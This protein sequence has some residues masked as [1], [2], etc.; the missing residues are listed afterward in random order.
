MPSYGRPDRKFQGGTSATGTSFPAIWLAV[1]GV[2]L[3]VAE[4]LYQG[5]LAG[6]PGGSWGWLAG[7]SAIAA[8]AAG[9]AW[10]HGGRSARSVAVGLVVL[11]VLLGVAAVRLRSVAVSPAA[12]AVRAT[13]DAVQSRDRT[14]AASVAAAR[15]VGMLALQRV[16][17]AAPGQAPVLDDLLGG[18]SIEMGV[19]VLGGDTVVAVA[20]PQRVGAEPAGTAASLVETPFARL[21]LVTAVRGN[22]RAQVTLLLD[23][24]SALPS[25]G[26]ALATS[27]GRSRGVEWQWRDAGSTPPV[28][29][30]ESAMAT[31]SN[32]MQPVPPSATAMMSRELILARRL[33]IA[34][35]ILLSAIILGGGAPPLVRAAA[36]LLPLWVLVRG[37]LVLEGAGGAI[38]IA[39]LAG[40]ALLLL[41]VV[42]WQR[43]AHRAPVGVIAAVI[44]LAVAPWLVL[45]AASELAPPSEQGG[46]LTWF[47]WQAILAITTGAYLALASA[48][49]RARGDQSTHGRWG[50]LATLASLM[51]AVAG[52]ELWTPATSSGW[53]WWYP[54][55][56][57]IPFAAMLPVTSPRARRVSIFTAAASLAALGAW[58]S[59][60]GERLASARTDVE[61]L[62]SS[63]DPVTVN[64]LDQLGIALAQSKD[65]RLEQIY[66]TWHASPMAAERIPTQLA[67]WVDTT[68]IDWVALD[69]MAPSWGDLQRVVVAG[70]GSMSQVPLARGEGR[71]TALIVPLDGDTAVT[72]LA[73]PRSRIVRPT[74]FGRMIDW[75]VAADPPYT[76]HE[77][78]PD[79]ARPD[80]TF[81]RTGR[82]IR[83]DEWVRTGGRPLIVRATVS[84]DEPRPF[85]VRAALTVLLDVLL[86]M[87]VW[88]LVERF[89]G[90]RRGG[91]ADVFRRSYRRTVT[92]ALISFFVVPAAFFTL[93]SVLRLRQEVAHDRGQDVTRVLH[94]IDDEPVLDDPGLGALP[95]VALAQVADRVDAEVAVY[96]S[97]RLVAASAPL[98]A[99]LGLLSPVIDP[100]IVRAGPA[101]ER[102]LAAPVPGANVRVGGQVSTVPGLVLAAALPGGEGDLER[103]QVDLALLLLLASL[104]GTIAAVSVAGAVARA[105]GQPMESLRQRALAIGRRELAPPLRDPPAEF[106]PVFTAIAQMERDLGQSEA[107]LEEE[108]ARTAR[109][110]AWGEMARQVAHEIKNPLTPM[111]LG[112]Q[113][114]QRLGADGH[115]DLSD[116]VSATADRL[117]E[118][119]DRLDRIAR[120]FARYGAP[121]QQLAGPLEQVDVGAVVREI[122]QLFGL[123]SGHVAVTVT[124]V[125]A[126]VSARR[127]ELIQVMLNLLDNARQAGA[128]DV[129]CLLDG[130]TLVVRDNG[131][132]IPAE[133]LESVFEPT[134]STTTSGTGLGLAI[135]RRLVEGWG[136]A[137]T[138]GSAE[139][140]GAEIV[141]RFVAGNSPTSDESA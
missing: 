120:S 108:T 87:L 39:V 12:A 26:R 78:R 88:W 96:R 36:L 126:V 84:I 4:A 92:A 59:S 57:L 14:L 91:E 16:G 79:E 89:L 6:G 35:M 2:A 102:G 24:A 137:V 25:P 60:L 90:Y 109:I 10:R 127:E 93:W 95:S 21:M 43:T 111:R 136:G 42:L 104:G 107:R 117:L 141:I 22:R 119:I 64:A 72:V 53:P 56:W 98:L 77:V 123:G 48:P 54:I 20:G 113:H 65:S 140:G 19:L 33:A 114:L 94:D 69:S 15:R 30:V 9:V 45:R 34:G 105:L 101:D 81:R 68:V 49:L 110:V 18:G 118:E 131:P 37:G 46:I 61:R 128:T 70:P 41:T 135:V 47:G 122:A 66:A 50:A 58:G 75:R 44:L 130:L 103:D 17:D 134:F 32:A 116:Q 8:V 83:A 63:S 124:G 125:G 38:S 132:G 76:L 80:F 52:I 106:L 62:G 23:A 121:P 85:A 13:A 11:M 74:R 115:P 3:A 97:G 7:A 28:T 40:A 139:A 99:E 67:V 100:A 31:I 112:L 133:Q 86:A 29:T 55:C 71:H 27:V 82:H 73:G 129:A 138:A 51:V 5:G 1:L